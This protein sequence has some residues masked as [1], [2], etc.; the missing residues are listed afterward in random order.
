MHPDYLPYSLSRWSHT[1]RVNR[2]SPGTRAQPKTSVESAS[3]L[4]SRVPK[5]LPPKLEMGQSVASGQ[6][7]VGLEGR[8]L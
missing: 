3:L 4:K 6:P 2:A 8:R 1:P 5:K 7:I